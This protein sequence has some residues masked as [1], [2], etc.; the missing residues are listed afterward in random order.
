MDP[1]QLASSEASRSVF[2]LFS[3]ESMDFEKVTHTV[4]ILGQMR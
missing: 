3:N 2:T 1:D 4:R